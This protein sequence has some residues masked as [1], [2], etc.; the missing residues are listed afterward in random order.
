M[1]RPS[2]AY[3]V[4]LDPGQCLDR[5]P[6]QAFESVSLVLLGVVMALFA[7]ML[8]NFCSGRKSGPQ[9]SSVSI[10]RLA[11]LLEVHVPWRHPTT[12]ES[13]TLGAGPAVGLNQPSWPGGAHSGLRTTA[14]K[15]DASA[16][17]GASLLAEP[18]LT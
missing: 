7:E 12:P 8:H 16:R 9:T 11:N 10:P 14:L 15:H 3:P 2:C 1:T 5:T 6:L 4:S 13:E 17:E 18:R